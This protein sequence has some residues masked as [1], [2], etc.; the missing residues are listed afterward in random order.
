[1]GMIIFIN[2]V[3]FY[4]I[5]QAMKQDQPLFEWMYKHTICKIISCS[6]ILITRFLWL[7]FFGKRMTIDNYA[8][9]CTGF[10]II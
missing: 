7:L 3:I 6:K 9:H 5:I 10:Q 1:M 4:L 8:A 2:T